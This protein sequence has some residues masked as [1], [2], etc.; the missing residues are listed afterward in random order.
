GI[1]LETNKK[2]LGWF[3][4]K[5]D[6]TFAMYHAGSAGFAHS[7][8]LL[9]PSKNAAVVVM[10]NTAEGGHA[11]EE[12]CF[13]LLPRFGLS[14]TDLFPAPIT[15]TIHQLQHIVSLPSSV[16]EKHAGNYGESGSYSAIRLKDHYL[17]LRNGDNQYLL[18]PLTANEFAPYRIHGKDTVE[19][20]DNSRYFFKDIKGYHV[21]I[22]RIGKREYNRGYRMDPLDTAL[23]RK[24]IGLY[25]HFGYQM[26]IG[27]SKFK[28]IEIYLS[29]DGVLM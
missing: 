3:M 10:T 27:D 25:E 7:K 14:I 2:G 26:L 23:L 18:K 29:N 9:L 19:A 11:A 15:G 16:L 1:P 12:F 17:E 20:K 5:N 24:K 8:L 28:S 6:S 21:L 4:F 22:Q 13:N